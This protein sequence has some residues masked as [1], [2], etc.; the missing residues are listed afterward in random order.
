MDSP[1]PGCLKGGRVDVNNKVH[2][3]IFRR[4]VTEVH[5]HQGQSKACQRRAHNKNLPLAIAR[6]LPTMVAC[7]TRIFQ[8][9]L[10]LV[11][12]E[13]LQIPASFYTSEHLGRDKA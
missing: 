8:R 7:N 10:D 11:Q 13:T 6:V 4:S 5:A 9:I 2:A 12:H 1:V 3:A